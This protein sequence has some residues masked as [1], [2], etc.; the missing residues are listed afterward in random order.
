MHA[1]VQ[2][3]R[4]QLDMAEMGNVADRLLISRHKIALRSCGNYRP[5]EKMVL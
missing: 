3:G 1:L 5:V 2:L 4:E